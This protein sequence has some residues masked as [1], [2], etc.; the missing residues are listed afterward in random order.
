MAVLDSLYGANH[1]LSVKWCC[2]ASICYRTTGTSSNVLFYYFTF[3]LPSK[4]RYILKKLIFMKRITLEVWRE[5][6]PC[7]WLLAGISYGKRLQCQ[8]SIIAGYFHHNSRYVIW[9]CCIWQSFCQNS[10]NAILPNSQCFD[11]DI[12]YIYLCEIR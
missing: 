1:P 8:T 7:P 11:T 9:S 10:R 2:H 12:S 4:T 3:R 5:Y 6:P